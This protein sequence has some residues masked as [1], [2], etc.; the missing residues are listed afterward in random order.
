MIAFIETIEKTLKPG[1]LWV[2]FGPLLYENE[3]QL[4]LS[5]EELRS[6]ILKFGFVFEVGFS[7]A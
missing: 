4:E 6:I 1:G 5:W 3:G 2:S 7:R